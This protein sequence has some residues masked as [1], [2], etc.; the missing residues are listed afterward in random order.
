MKICLVCQIL[1]TGDAKLSMR[2]KQER[3]KAVNAKASQV[4]SD[5]QWK[6]TPETVKEINSQYGKIAWRSHSLP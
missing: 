2:V 5:M 3:L 4:E 6:H 1:F